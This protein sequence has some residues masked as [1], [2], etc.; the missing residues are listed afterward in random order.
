MIIFITIINVLLPI[1]LVVMCFLILDSLR[2]LKNQEKSRHDM[3]RAYMEQNKET[4]KTLQ[5]L[6]LHKNEKKE[7]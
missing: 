5:D 3:M 2:E 6:L 7:S 1:A 4:L